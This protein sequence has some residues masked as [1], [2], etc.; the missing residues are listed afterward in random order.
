MKKYIIKNADGS[1]QHVMEAVHASSKEAGQTLWDYLLDRNDGG[2]LDRYDEGWVSPFDFI[3]EEE[4][5]KDEKYKLIDDKKSKILYSNIWQ[6][7]EAGETKLNAE[8]NKY[9][10]L[11]IGCYA[12]IYMPPKEKRKCIRIRAVDAI[13]QET[14]DLDKIKKITNYKL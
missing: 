13:T 14:F 1:E 3:I 8:K 12:S 6:I 7:Q 11:F 2:A 9:F 10:D 4:E 5:C